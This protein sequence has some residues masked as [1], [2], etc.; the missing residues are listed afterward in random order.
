MFAANIKKQ[1]DFRNQQF[2]LTA[3]DT[4]NFLTSYDGIL[5]KSQ[6]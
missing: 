1:N 4:E 2:D 6:I 3:A 5:N